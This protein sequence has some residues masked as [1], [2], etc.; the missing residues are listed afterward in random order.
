MLSSVSPR[1]GT[2]GGG[3]ESWDGTAVPQ[4][5]GRLKLS[6]HKIVD[7]HSAGAY[8]AGPVLTLLVVPP[9]AQ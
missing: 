2:A 6:H 9:E 7:N 3:G 8:R 4:V 1:D 5:G